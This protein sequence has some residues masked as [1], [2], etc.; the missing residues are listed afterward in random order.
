MRAV[1]IAKALY[2]Q[3]GAKKGSASR[4]REGGGGQNTTDLVKKTFK[5]I[6]YMK[7][8]PQAFYLSVCSQKRRMQ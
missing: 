4:G 8:L 5:K 3:A 7:A 1:V 2:S 6:P